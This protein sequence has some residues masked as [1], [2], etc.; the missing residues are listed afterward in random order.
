MGGASRTDVPFFGF[1]HGIVM[2]SIL[3]TWIYNNTRSSL[4]P[5]I[6]VHALMNA[7]VFPTWES[8]SSAWMFVLIW[9]LVTVALVVFWGP[10]SLV[11]ENSAPSHPSH[12][13]GSGPGG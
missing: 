6:L 7:Q 13:P 3:L 9:T 10:R 2:E 8:P 1:C 4:L 5:V 12:S 11:R